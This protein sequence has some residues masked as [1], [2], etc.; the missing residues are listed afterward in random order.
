[1]FCWLDSLH[2]RWRCNEKIKFH[3]F[4][5]SDVSDLHCWVSRRI[6]NY[7]KYFTRGYFYPEFSSGC[8]VSFWLILTGTSRFFK[9][10]VILYTFIPNILIL[11]IGLKHRTTYIFL[12]VLCGPIWGLA[13]IIIAHCIGPHRNT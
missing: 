8:I 7:H 11:H 3:C 12:V 9:L 1:M 13:W 5:I 2:V 10:H 6:L 4:W